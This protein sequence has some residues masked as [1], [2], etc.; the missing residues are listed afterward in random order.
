MKIAPPREFLPAIKGKALLL[1]TNIFIDAFS[2]PSEFTRFFNDLRSKDN[3]V[4]LVTIDHVLIEFLKGAATESRL[5]EKKTYL[6]SI[7]D[8]YLP[9]TKDLL[10]EV[11]K[12]LREYK[13]ESKDISIT[14]LYLGGMLVKYK[15][16]I[17]LLTKDLADFP[18]SIFERTSYV[19][20]LENKSIRN[21]GVYCY[22]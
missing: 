13:I 9:V 17:C 18:E 5:N 4:T 10:D 6:E 1:D 22:K 19:T 3:D 15:N 16:N 7:I 8:T 2:H 12:L 11:M 20:L 14:D 21:Y